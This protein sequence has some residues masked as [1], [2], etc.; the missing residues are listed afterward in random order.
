MFR[1]LRTKGVRIGRKRVETLMRDNGLVSRKKRRFRPQTTDSNHQGPFAPNRLEQ[2]FHADAP[3]QVWVGDITYCKT[4]EGWLYLAVV[5]DVYSRRV[6]GWATSPS[7]EAGV[8][9]EA[10]QRAMELRRPAPGQGRPICV[11]GLSDSIRKTP[12]PCQYEPNRKLLRQCD[13]RKL[14]FNPGI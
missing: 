9:V 5:L 4:S 14:F 7:L 3:N 8:A 11:E 6:V 12:C 1:E 13:G 2:N 10:L